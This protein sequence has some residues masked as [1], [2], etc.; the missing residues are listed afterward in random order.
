MP[1]SKPRHHATDSSGVTDGTRVTRSTANWIHYHSTVECRR[2]PQY[3]T[4]AHVLQDC[5]IYSEHRQAMWPDGATLQQKL[6]GSKEDLDTTARFLTSTGLQAT[7]RTQKKKKLCLHV[8]LWARSAAPNF[9]SSC[10]CLQ[11][12]ATC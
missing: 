4:P 8:L 2:Y 11:T 1:G 9:T 6:W 12:T 3:Q 7:H 5:P 10:T